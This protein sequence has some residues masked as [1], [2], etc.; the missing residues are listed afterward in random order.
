[1]TYDYSLV[2]IRL[3]QMKMVWNII[4]GWQSRSEHLH[5]T[6]KILQSN[7]REKLI[8]STYILCKS[9]AKRAEVGQS[10]PDR[11]EEP[12]SPEEVLRY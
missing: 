11:E 4:K 5:E 9:E 3:Y 12:V 6:E 1:M 10:S 8:Y 7:L 2:W